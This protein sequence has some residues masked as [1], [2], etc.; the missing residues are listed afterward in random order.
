MAV[1]VRCAECPLREVGLFEPIADE[2]R[3]IVEELRLPQQCKPAG[4]TLIAEGQDDAPLF[5]LFA[6][7]A[8]RF[9]TL[10]DGRRQVLNFLVPGDF[11]G[12]QEK[13][14][15]A[16]LHGVEALTEVWLCPFQRDALWQIHRGAPQLGYAITWLA[17][18]EESL[19]DENLLSIGRR[20]AAERIAT[21]LLVLYKR[22]AALQDPIPRDGVVFPLTQQLIADA[23]G[24]SLAHTH[25]T[26]RLLE[27]RGLHRIRDGRLQ[28]INPAALERL[29]D[30]W[31]DGR[32][33]IRPLV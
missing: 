21:L 19:V 5:T 2:H 29:A 7:W 33:V 3:L 16:S 32:P 15:H 24:L 6:G 22:A 13:L 23:M 9:K 8:Y 17:A 27:R 26:L 4:A 14:V 31:D 1:T 30:V 12:L 10:R 18:H 25:R 28:I 20:S 11:V